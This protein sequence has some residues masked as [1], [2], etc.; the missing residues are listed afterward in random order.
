MNR[1][2][3]EVMAK[4]SRLYMFVLF[5]VLKESCLGLDVDLSFDERRLLFGVFGMGRIPSRPAPSLVF[6]MKVLMF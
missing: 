1:R 3:D 4:G 2:E 5:G 6:R